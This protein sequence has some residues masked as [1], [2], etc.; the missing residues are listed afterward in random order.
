M[1]QWVL[2]MGLRKFQE[3]VFTSRPFTAKEMY[4][5]QFVNSVAPRERLEE[6]TRKYALACSKHG[7]C[8][9]AKEM[10]CLRRASSWA[11]SYTTTTRWC[12]PFRAEN[13]PRGCA[14]KSRGDAHQ[15]TQE[16][17]RVLARGAMLL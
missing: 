10:P 9:S 11:W 17:R 6:E 3:M 4:E 8:A 2:M 7:V 13:K 5:C 15:G 12:P 14:S 1:W 16:F